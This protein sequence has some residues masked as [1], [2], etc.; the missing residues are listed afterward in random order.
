MFKRFGRLLWAGVF[1]LCV[2][3]GAYSSAWAGDLSDRLASFPDWR[4]PPKGAVAQGEL[5]YPDWFEGS[6]QATTTLK[7]A[8]APLSPDIVTPGFEQNK[9]SLGQPVE[10]TVRF[11]DEVMDRP[12]QGLRG[13][14]GLGIEPQATGIVA[15]RVFNTKSL[16]D[17][18]VHPGY[19]KSVDLDPDDFSRLIT[20]FEG[21]QQLVSESRER[22]IEQESPQDFIS[23][24]MFIQTFR[25]VDEIYLNRVENTT[26]Y[27]QVNPDRIEA[28]QITAIYL[29]PKD[30]DFFRARNRPVALYRY[31]LILER[32]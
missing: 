25:T 29:S 30:P 26:G 20:Q 3:L 10:F 31:D 7:D 16:A 14:T 5:I 24:E 13:I 17:A 28:D 27:N 12:V 4:S 19:V 9:A 21:G 6:W 18:A 11:S 22:A 32:S 8:V 15:D 1:A 2:S 23:S